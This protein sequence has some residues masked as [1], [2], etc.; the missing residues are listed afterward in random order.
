MP[1]QKYD[2]AKIVFTFAVIGLSVLLVSG[3][4]MVQA[5]DRNTALQEAS[6]KGDEKE[7][8]RLLNEGADINAKDKSG[9]TALMSASWKCHVGVVKAL[10][11]KGANVH[12]VDKDGAT[13]L[14]ESSFGGNLDVMKALLGKGADSVGFQSEWSE[15]VRI[16]HNRPDRGGGFSL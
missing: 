15:R 11:D 3:A 2:I 12:A 9:S 6:K 7:V 1:K 16:F 8:T 4:N 5:E 13:A 10:L 14:M